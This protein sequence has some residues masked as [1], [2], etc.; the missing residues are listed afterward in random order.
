VFID[1]PFG[2][3]AVE[4]CGVNL[5]LIMNAGP[6]GAGDKG[7][8]KPVAANRLGQNQP[9]TEENRDQRNTKSQP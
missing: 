2:L 8:C 9:Q 6:P 1:V 5:C 4:L 7:G 3:F